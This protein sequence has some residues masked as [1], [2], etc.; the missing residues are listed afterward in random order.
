MTKLTP[1]LWAERN[2]ILPA[3][4]PIPGPFNPNLTP[5]LTPICQ[6]FDNPQYAVFVLITGVQMGKTSTIFNIMGW[7]ADTLNAPQIYIGPSKN[8]IDSVIAPKFLQMVRECRVLSDKY[9][10]GKDSSKYARIIGG[11]SVRF[12]WAGSASEVASDSARI[13]VVDEL[14]RPEIAATGEGNL[15]ELAYNRGEGFIDSK[16]LLTSTPTE[17]QLDTCVH[18]KTGIEH[19]K[20]MPPEKVVSPI[21]AEWQTG[22]RHEWAIPCSACLVYFI[23]RRKHLWYPDDATP[24][25][26]EKTAALKCP[27]CGHLNDESERIAKNQQGRFI[28]PGETVDPDGTI[29]GVADTANSGR[30]T[31]WISGLCSFSAKKTYG[32]LAKR[33]AQAEFNND[34]EKKRAVINTGFGE[35]YFLSGERPSAE[36]VFEHRSTLYTLADIGGIRSKILRVTMGVDV[37]ADRLFYALRGWGEYRTS[38]LLGYGE[39]IGDTDKTAV[40]QELVN[41]LESGVHAFPID[42]AA[43]DSGYRTDIVYAFC[44]EFWEQC[45]PTKGVDYLPKFFQP[46]LQDVNFQGKSMKAGVK[47]WRFNTDRAKTWVHSR[48]NWPLHKPGGFHLPDDV[49]T[50]Y[51]QQLIAEHRTIERGKPV[52]VEL[53]PNHYFDCE[54]L[55][56]VALVA[57]DDPQLDEGVAFGKAGENES[58]FRRPQQVAQHTP[59]HVAQDL[60]SRLRNDD[61][62]SNDWL[63]RSN[64]GG[65]HRSP[66][67]NWIR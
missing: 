27:A 18:P 50:D 52:W 9:S 55:S 22:T 66:A 49:T 23:P 29:R 38:Y 67:G 8:N 60:E 30:L 45:M 57:L 47:L 25:Q 63:G 5:Y 35:L 46:S 24:E 42:R 6:E 41:I 14:D 56:Y 21:W 2:R 61:R 20:V 17:G 62:A 39:L 33:W 3:S 58:A 48:L 31:Q 16:L 36:Q 10:H 59:E 40:W 37:Q 44:R 15:V 53:G 65:W 28:A 19:W 1:D 7:A 12:G 4:S 26:A 13:T 51:Q 32:S 11:V 64:S 54:V 43:I 34:P